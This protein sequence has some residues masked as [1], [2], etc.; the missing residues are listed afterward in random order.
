MFAVGEKLSEAADDTC[1]HFFLG[2]GG[3]GDQVCRAMIDEDGP[4]TGILMEAKSTYTMHLTRLGRV[5]CPFYI[6][7]GFIG[8]GG[9]MMQV[10]T[11]RYLYNNTSRGGIS[12]MLISYIHM[13]CSSTGSVPLAFPNSHRIIN[14]ILL[15]PLCLM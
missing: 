14:F 8:D 10:L 2:G 12:R 6:G 1:M 4:T 3:G 7:K 9:C 13:Y 11:Y 15:H 5:R